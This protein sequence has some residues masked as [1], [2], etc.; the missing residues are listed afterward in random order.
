M[1]LTDETEDEDV[2]KEYIEETNRDAVMI[3]A[4]KL[5]AS[6]AVPKVSIVLFV[7]F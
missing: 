5:V 6:D 7:C 2:N 1:F 4:A 3:A